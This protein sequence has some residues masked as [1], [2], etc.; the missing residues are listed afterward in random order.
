MKV[1]NKS[2]I[3]KKYSFT[4][5]TFLSAALLVG[6]FSKADLMPLN[7]VE[8]ASHKLVSLVKNVQVPKEMSADLT[9]IL[10]K[11]TDKLEIYLMAPSKEAGKL[12]SVLLKYDV[13]SGKLTD[14]KI[15][16]V[17]AS[18]KDSIYPNGDGATLLDLAVEAIVD[19]LTEEPALNDVNNLAETIKVSVSKST[20][21]KDAIAYEIGL[22]DKRVYRIEMGKDSKVIRKGFK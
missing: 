1:I 5:A 19:H 10:I 22:T 21:G 7:A 17:Q 11:K 20:D 14:Q 3:Q 9:E 8:K 4:Y 2:N 15:A 13:V 12:N 6:S 18:G 16:F